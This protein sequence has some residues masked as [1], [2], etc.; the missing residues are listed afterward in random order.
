MTVVATQD[1]SATA[2]SALAGSAVVAAGAATIA[3]S[4]AGV[5]GTVLRVLRP[6]GWAL[7][8]LAVVIGLWFAFIKLA[9]INPLVGKSPVDVFKF[10]WNG[11]ANGQSASDVWSLL[12]RTLWDSL[13]GLIAGLVIAIAVALGFVMSRLLE[14]T[15]LPMAVIVAAIPLVAMTPLIT[16]V[17]GRGT[18]GTTFISGLVVFFPALVTVT[19]GLRTTS[20]QAAELCRVYGA[21][22]FSIARK[23][24]IPSALPAIFAATRIAVPG[25]LVGAMLA[26]YLASGKG[27]GYG[28]LRDAQT[29][30][31]DS[32]WA[33]VAILTFVSVVVYY[34]VQAAESVVLARFS[35]AAGRR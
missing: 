15:L 2:D 29:F 4:G 20:K 8:S 11:G 31:Y 7:L 18:V 32:V 13:L 19:Y 26:E 27:L 17:F 12:G 10:F 23:V 24:M 6:L 5:G 21:S 25:S 35:V 30:S 14:R 33:S 3:S 16:L 1:S 34:L 28:I 22:T 9:K